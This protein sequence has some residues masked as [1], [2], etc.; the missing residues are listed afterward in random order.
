MKKKKEEKNKL[1][2]ERSTPQLPAFVILLTIIWVSNND[3]NV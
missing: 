3:S 1:S 2:R